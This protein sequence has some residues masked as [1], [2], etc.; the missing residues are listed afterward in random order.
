MSGYG[1]IYLL[2]P[3]QAAVYTKVVADTLF[4]LH[5]ESDWC[6]AAMELVDM[7]GALAGRVREYGGVL[8][9]EFRVGEVLHYKISDDQ[10]E[11][12]AEVPAL[13]TAH[14]LLYREVGGKGCC[15]LEVGSNAHKNAMKL[16]GLGHLIAGA[17]TRLGGGDFTMQVFYMNQTEGGDDGKRA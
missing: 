8:F 4:Y 7:G 11:S 6:R 12:T 3:M 5:A 13:Q 10:P 1:K 9:R 17:T 15:W 2:T 14:L 16:V